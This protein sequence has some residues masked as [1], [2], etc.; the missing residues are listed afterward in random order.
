MK[1]ILLTLLAISLWGQQA[2]KPEPKSADPKID[3][4]APDKALA[5]VPL[6][7]QGTLELKDIE[8]D[9]E[10]LGEAINKLAAEID[11]PFAARRN[12][13]ITSECE[14]FGLSAEKQECGVDLRSRTVIF[15]VPPK[16]TPAAEKPEPK[17]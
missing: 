15:R 13:V 7:K 1:T 17:K 14:R 11:K 9:E 5:P 12:A 2:E 4:K 6:S 10:P 8:H 3:A 16:I